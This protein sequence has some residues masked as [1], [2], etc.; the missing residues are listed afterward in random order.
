MNQA[1]PSTQAAPV[2]QM[3]GV[4]NDDG[5]LLIGLRADGSP[6]W[7]DPANPLPL[8]RVM[9]FTE[10]DARCKAWELAGAGHGPT[11]ISQLHHG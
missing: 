3:H 4:I 8:R 7:D 2:E 6:V 11:G 9:H 5:E 10:H 1:Q